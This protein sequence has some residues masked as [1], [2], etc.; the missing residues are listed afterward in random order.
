M[1]D[2]PLI[3][4]S[5]RYAVCC[6]FRPQLLA[7][8]CKLIISFLP[9]PAPNALRLRVSP[10]TRIIATS[11]F[12]LLRT[13]MWYDS[14]LFLVPGRFWSGAHYSTSIRIISRSTRVW[15]ERAELALKFCQPLPSQRAQHHGWQVCLAPRHLGSTAATADA[16]QNKSAVHGRLP[17]RP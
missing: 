1:Y 9:G 13:S 8:K 17:R 4:S 6:P 7:M 14:N 10:A 2:C 15:I 16:Q 5:Q 12:K 11:Y 3:S